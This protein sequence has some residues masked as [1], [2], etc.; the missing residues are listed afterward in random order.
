MLTYT[1]SRGA[2][3]CKPVTRDGAKVFVSDNGCS[4]DWTRIILLDASISRKDEE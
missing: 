1:L 2:F 3:T 4:L